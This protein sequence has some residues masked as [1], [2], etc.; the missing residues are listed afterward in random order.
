MAFFQGVVALIHAEQPVEAFPLLG[1]L[2]RIA[3]RFEQIIQPNGPGLGIHFVQHWTHLEP[4][5][6]TQMS[7]TGQPRQFPTRPLVRE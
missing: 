7:L 4:S 6:L 2:T 5:A 3:A 1:G